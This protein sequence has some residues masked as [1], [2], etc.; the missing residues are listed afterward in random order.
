MDRRIFETYTQEELQ[1][2]DEQ[3]EL[4]A[5]DIPDE[6]RKAVFYSIFYVLLSVFE[7]HV[8]YT[9]FHIIA[10]DDNPF[11]TPSIMGFSAIVIVVGLHLLARRNRQHPTI[12]FV[13]GVVEKML[14]VYL[15][16]IG[17]L[18]TVLLYKYGLGALLDTDQA[19]L[20]FE[21]MQMEGQ[22][23]VSW[24]MVHIASPLAALV[25]STGLGALAVINVFVAMNAFDKAASANKTANTL[26][27]NQSANKADI[28]IYFDA[29]ATFEDTLSELNA[30]HIVS[31]EQLRAEISGEL[32]RQLQQANDQALSSL[33][34]TL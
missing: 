25:F 14:P 19:K 9:V 21:T 23:W 33:A 24:L 10:G 3:S 13:D 15:V 27:Y 1:R 17:L 6:R 20:N 26:A 4:A 12:R 30:Q 18:L 8:L 22:S 16:G 11:W 31:D 34:E 28:D 7:Y 29:L 32:S 5:K 2:L